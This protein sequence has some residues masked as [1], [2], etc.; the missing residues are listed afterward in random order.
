MV[1]VHDRRHRTAELDAGDEGG[2]RARV[3][4]DDLHLDLIEATG[5]RQDLGRYDDLAD[6]VQ[7]TSRLHHLDAR[8]VVSQPGGD[9]AGKLRDALLMTGGVGIAQL[10]RDAEG[11]NCRRQRL[12]ELRCIRLD[13]GRGAL[14]LADVSDEAEVARRRQAHGIDARWE[15]GAVFAQED[16]IAACVPGPAKRPAKCRRPQLRDCHRG[17]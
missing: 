16:T 5:L 4:T 1:L 15:G 14:L 9:G 7:Q 12:L 2:A 17:R 8:L 11:G 6:V 13:L 10:G 3:L